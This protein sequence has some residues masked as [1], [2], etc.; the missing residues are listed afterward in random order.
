MEKRLDFVAVDFETLQAA[1]NDGK[2][3]HKLPIQIGMQRYI[4][5]RPDGLPYRRFI[6][7]PVDIPWNAISK[8][9]ITWKD[10]EGE[11]TYDAL[12]PEIVEYIG[13]LPIVAF[14]YTSE[15]GAFRDACAYYGLENPYPKSRFIDPYL[16]Y[17]VNYQYIGRKPN[18]E[19]GLSYWCRC[20]GLE[21]SEFRPH[22]ASDDAQLCARLYI[23]LRSVSLEGQFER[24]PANIG[25]FQAKDEQKDE[26]L[27]G[28]P[29]PEE[30][31]IHPDNPFNRRYVVVTGFACEVENRINRKLIQLGAGRMDKIRKGAQVLVV[32]PSSMDKYAH[33]P[34]GKIKQALEKN[35]QVMDVYEL[36]EILQA[37]GVYEGELEEI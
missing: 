6:K 20:L 15:Y 1:A 23:Y 3:Y 2:L 14:N 21:S 36:K 37:Y 30:E 24:K 31:V 17:L 4:D 28:D 32:S 10:C 19:S 27:F 11:D 7:P 5:G 26:S 33:P 18:D 13:D 12:H 16:H 35:M 34:K 29:I 22:D 9:G 8:V 25:R